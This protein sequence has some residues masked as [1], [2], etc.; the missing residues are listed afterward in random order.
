MIKSSKTWKVKNLKTKYN[1]ETDNIHKFI[2]KE[3]SK[4]DYTGISNDFDIS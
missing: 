3:D 4:L 1:K 2:N